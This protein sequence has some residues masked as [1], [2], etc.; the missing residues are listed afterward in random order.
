MSPTKMATEGIGGSSTDVAVGVE[1]EERIQVLKGLSAGE[2]VLLGRA[3][4]D[5]QD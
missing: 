4:Q 3:Q 5:E 1:N 2:R